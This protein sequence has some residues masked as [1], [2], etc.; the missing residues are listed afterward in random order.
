[1]MRLW[2]V[3]PSIRVEWGLKYVR[4]ARHR[5]ALAEISLIRMEPN[6]LL[7]IQCRFSQSH[8]DNSNLKCRRRAIQAVIDSNL[9]SIDSGDRLVPLSQGQ[10]K[11][12]SAHY[13]GSEYT[14]G[15]DW[16]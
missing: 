7:L 4:P 10:C 9:S 2:A 5:Y 8:C 3:L 6:E 12:F 11:M 13:S 16:T 15:K 14:H 1:M